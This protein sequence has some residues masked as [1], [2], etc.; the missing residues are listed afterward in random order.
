MIEHVNCNDAMPLVEQI[1]WN[2]KPP[3]Y[4]NG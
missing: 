1:T 3:T 2:N 4:I